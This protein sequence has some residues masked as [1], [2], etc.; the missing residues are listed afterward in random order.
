LKKKFH[1]INTELFTLYSDE[2]RD[3]WSYLEEDELRFTCEEVALPAEEY[4]ICQDAKTMLH[5]KGLQLYGNSLS[6][7]LLKAR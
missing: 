5:A 4:K 7:P 3:K 6:P 1:Q 2:R